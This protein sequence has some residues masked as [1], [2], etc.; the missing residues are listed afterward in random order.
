MAETISIIGNIATVCALVWAIITTARTRRD[1]L[2]ETRRQFDLGILAE[3][4]RVLSETGSVSPLQGHV[5]ALVRDRNNSPDLALLRAYLG[6][7][8]DAAGQSLLEGMAS[9]KSTDR[10]LLDAAQAEI[11]DAINRRISAVRG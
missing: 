8:P 9:M 7:K 11:D 2:K 5:G 1:L 4:W 6:V 3:M 10:T